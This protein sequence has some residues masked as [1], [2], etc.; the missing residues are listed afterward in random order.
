MA[1]FSFALQSSICYYLAILL[2]SMI[3]RQGLLDQK[4]RP[5]SKEHQALI[6][7]LIDSVN[8]FDV[9]KA[10]NVRIKN[11][12]KECPLNKDIILYI[13]LFCNSRYSQAESRLRE[14]LHI[15]GGQLQ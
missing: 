1:L 4:L 2:K 11:K 9:V 3:V 10:Q 6:E 7:L 8:S 12:F 5:M 15:A 13:S 14:R